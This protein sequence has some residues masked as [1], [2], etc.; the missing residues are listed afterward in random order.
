MLQSL[1]EFGI[2]DGQIIFMEVYEEAIE[3]WPSNLI[4]KD[5]RNA[6]QGIQGKT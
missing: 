2:T 4:K 1:E 6:L 3:N 5:E